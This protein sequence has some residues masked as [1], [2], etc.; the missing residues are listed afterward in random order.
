MGLK[1]MNPGRNTDKEG[2]Q[3]LEAHKGRERCGPGI[4][5]CV[6]KASAVVNTERCE[7]RVELGKSYESRR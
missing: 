3:K 5:S 7:V 2:P 6:I 1:E 4:E